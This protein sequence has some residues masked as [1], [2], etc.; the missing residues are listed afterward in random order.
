MSLRKSLTLS[1]LFAALA[2][3][4]LA[5]PAPNMEEGNWE[6]T[7]KMQMEGMPFAMPPMKVNQ[8]LTKKDM[9]PNASADKNSCDV[10]EQKVSGDTVTWRMVCK[11]PEGT[12]ENEGKI[13]YFG[14]LYEGTMHTKTTPKQGGETMSASYQLQGRHTGACM[15]APKPNKKAGD[16]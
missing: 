7:M 2:V 16:Y 11:D 10:K 15:A 5:A 3:P 12:T 6:V 8:C 9:L 13:T 1:C 4:A 14:K